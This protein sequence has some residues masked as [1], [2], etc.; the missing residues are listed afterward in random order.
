MPEPVIDGDLIMV[1]RLF[2][3]TEAEM[4]RGRL[5]AEGVPAIVAD[6]H[7]ARVISALQVAIG[8][9]R[10]L[11]P[12]AYLEKAREVLRADARGDYAIDENIDMGAPSEPTGASQRH[13]KL[14]SKPVRLRSFVSMVW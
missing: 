8:G 1:A 3:P 9:V 2:D 5:E 12:E 13:P 11:V 6:A 4:L 7:T 14:G 10:I